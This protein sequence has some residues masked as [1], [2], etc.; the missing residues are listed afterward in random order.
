MYK[1][2]ENR[3]IYLKKSGKF[4][5]LY[6]SPSE[7]NIWECLILVKN[8]A[9]CQDYCTHCRGW[10]YETTCKGENR[11]KNEYLHQRWK[12]QAP[13]F[14][15]FYFITAK[16]QDAKTASSTT[17]F[18]ILSPAS[19]STLRRLSETKT[20]W[21]GFTTAS[22]CRWHH[23]L[24]LRTSRCSSGL[25]PAHPSPRT[26]TASLSATSMCHQQD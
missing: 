17:M 13:F 21:S 6:A 1:I 9:D 23:A 12:G 10:P 16:D 20:A 3:P 25:L 15:V 14:P 2:K 8:Q 11:F 5:Y 22:G 19:T 24:W 26:H 4:D 7:M 18:S